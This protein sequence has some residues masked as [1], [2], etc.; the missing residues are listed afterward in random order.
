MSLLVIILLFALVILVIVTF[1]L[2][3]FAK[4][5]LKNDSHNLSITVLILLVVQFILGMIN[6]FWVTIPKVESYVVYHQIGPVLFHTYNA[7]FILVFSILYLLSVHKKKE[8]I[9]LPR[10]GIGSIV[11]A[12]IAGVLFVN[13]GGQNDIY[14]FIMALGFLCAFIIYSYTSFAYKR[15]KQAE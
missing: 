15:K 14:S 11:V 9:L 5:I 1:L 2:Y 10:I 12:F 8:S 7:Y 3:L 13:S 6:N 4:K